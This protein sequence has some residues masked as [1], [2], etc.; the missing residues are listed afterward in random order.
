MFLYADAALFALFVWWFSTGAILFLD[1][2]PRATFK[3]SIAAATVLTVAA[4]FGLAHSAQDATPNGAFMAFACG[5]TVWAWQE[6]TFYM[7][8]VT[9][10][11]KHLCEDGCGGWKH[12]GHA[13]QVSLWHELSIIAFAMGVVALTWGGTNQVGTY[14][15]M[16][17]W[18][19]HESAR[20]NVMLGVRNLN[21]EF[22]P[23]H[24]FYLRSFLK[25]RPMNGL[26]PI[27]VTV[28][29]VACAVMVRQALAPDASA[30]TQTG[31]T[32]VAAMMALAILEHW[33]LVLPFPTAILWRWGLA[34]RGPRQQFEVQIVTGFLGAGKTT[35]LRR[36]LAQAASSATEAGQRTVV[37]LNDFAA[38]GVDGSIL[39]GSGKIGS[40]KGSAQLPKGC[41]CCVLKQD[42]AEQLAD[43][44]ARYNPAQ[45]LIEP[46]GVAD[47]PA[48]LLAL[49]APEV[50]PHVA[51][52][53][54]TAVLDAGAFLTD[55][56]RMAR[57]MR[58]QIA[59]SSRVILN[60]TDVVSA[61]TLAMVAETVHGIAPVARVVPARFG[62]ADETANLAMHDAAQPCCDKHA[63]GHAQAKFNGL[64]A[65]YD[66]DQGHGVLGLTS[67][68]TALHAPCDA[69]G[70]QNVLEAVVLGRFGQ[71]E[72]M[73]GVV[74]SGTGWVR[75][76][77]AGGRP[78][79]AEFAPNRKESGRVVAIGRQVDEE[80]LRAAFKA[81]AAA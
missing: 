2:L 18:W 49:K 30:F 78:S 59:A 72:R 32:L 68:S 54:V 61:A 47:L 52:V 76:D 64:V 73:K 24:L 65:D 41:V 3:Y 70:L 13:I 4:M 51:G 9:G 8:F 25:K 40:G 67:W 71:V 26:F 56:G 36:L 17:L 1:G 58:T 74:R 42:V 29:T 22:L 31:M 16:V 57:H 15:F 80:R 66:A 79:M 53:Q 62:L 7:G 19:M 75:F 37:V 48:L 10:P 77:V 39:T 44:A 23:D 46:S 50:A 35:Y 27:S 12:F 45:V 63:H 28:S 20:L 6:I 55:F 33:F 43:I 38:V 14:T 11:R 81:C 69:D 34:S 21:E 5:L 60:K